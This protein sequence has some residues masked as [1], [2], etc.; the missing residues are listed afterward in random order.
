MITSLIKNILPKPAKM[1]LIVR[2]DLKLSKG[3]T[4]SQSAHAAVLCYQTALKSNSKLASQWSLMGQPKIVLKVDSL[5]E[6][7]NL[8]KRAR[9]M[10]LIAE[11]VRDA[12]RTQIEAGT[13]TA[14][15]LLDYSD[16][17]DALTKDLKLL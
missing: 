3:K 11:M 12:G 2:N 9:A 8:F 15:G 5:E 16:R 6:L 4:A 13:K 1:A 14:I 17:V 7:E 10:N